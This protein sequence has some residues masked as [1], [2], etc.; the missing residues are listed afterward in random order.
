MIDSIPAAATAR[1][2]VRNI[3]DFALVGSWHLN[4]PGI[5]SPEQFYIEK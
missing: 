4:F 2:D 3:Q 5:I 1:K